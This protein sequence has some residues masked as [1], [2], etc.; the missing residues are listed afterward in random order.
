MGPH[1]PLIFC[2]HPTS[3]GFPLLRAERFGLRGFVRDFLSL[4]EVC[5]P[6]CDPAA[7]TSGCL[8]RPVSF[9]HG[10]QETLRL[11]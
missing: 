1:L 9:L 5:A 2:L 6:V 7:W 10:K 4:P 8:Q 11:V 3:F